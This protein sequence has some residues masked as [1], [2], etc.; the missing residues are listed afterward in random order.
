MVVLR[1]QAKST[2]KTNGNENNNS[3]INNNTHNNS[4]EDNTNSHTNNN[5]HNNSAKDNNNSNNHNNNPN[6]NEEA[7]TDHKNNNHKKRQYS[8]KRNS[9]A[10]KEIPHYQFFNNE[11]V[12]SGN[13]IAPDSFQFNN[14]TSSS[15][16]SISKNAKD[17]EKEC[18]RKLFDD[19]EEINT[20]DNNGNNKN[21]KHSINDKAIHTH[22]KQANQRRMN[23]NHNNDNHPQDDAKN[24]NNYQDH[25]SNHN[26]E[27]SLIKHHVGVA[28]IIKSQAGNTGN[29]Q[30][31]KPN[32]VN[33]DNSSSVSNMI[34]NLNIITSSRS[35]RSKTGAKKQKLSSSSTSNSSTSSS[36]NRL[37]YCDGTCNSE[38]GIAQSFKQFQSYVNHHRSM[39]HLTSSLEIASAINQCQHN[40]LN[41]NKR[42]Y[43]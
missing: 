34:D 10:A 23:H 4:E 5:T 25:H 39:H 42:K 43:I 28:G 6:N 12:D 27:S 7:N 16:S 18:I 21:I 24:N 2:S 35:L 30:D 33:Q 13:Y 37:W 32:D 14:A 8:P 36:K 11:S 41:G 19:E 22:K 17:F 15:T 38:N 31:T 1:S 20:K 26:K 40:I 29:L 3:H 9:N